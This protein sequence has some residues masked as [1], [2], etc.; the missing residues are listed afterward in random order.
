MPTITRLIVV[1][2]GE[3]EDNVARRPQGQAHGTLTERGVAQARRVGR[4]LAGEDFS[5][6][7]SS[8]LNRAYHTA[9]IIAGQTRHEIIIA[10]CL[11]E[12]HFGVF[13]GLT[14][15]EIERLYPDEHASYRLGD[16]D[17]AVPEGEST[18]QLCARSLACVEGIALDH[19][20]ETIVIV[21]HGGVLN[22]LLRMVLGIPLNAP[23][24]FSAR[25]ASVNVFLFDGESWQLET[26]G[27]VC[28]LRDLANGVDRR[29]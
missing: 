12:R 15:T 22:C 18:R 21:S 29:S 10:E 26:W 9:Q 24:R 8:D 16:P 14:W 23:R 17:Y 6:L 7:Y 3:T 4:R 25:N 11:R 27:D 5:H 20:E 28:H 2:H 1:R 13:Q 19:P